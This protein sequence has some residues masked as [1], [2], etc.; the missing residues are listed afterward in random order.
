MAA[1]YIE[2]NQR[3]YNNTV[4][5]KTYSLNPGNTT[6]AITKFITCSA[7]R[8]TTVAT[9]NM[10][11]HG[12][13]VGDSI[14]VTG[15]A[16]FAGTF[17]IATVPDGDTFTYAVSNANATSATI[18]VQITLVTQNYFRGQGSISPVIQVS[19]TL[20][21]LQALFP[22]ASSTKLSVIGDGSSATFAAVA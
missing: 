4:G 8:V 11:G 14:V 17:T 9:V 13:L 1:Q 10:P 5:A 3:K 7:T 16:P 20:T 19:G 2:I 15:L 12:F 22:T 21:A 6:K 18:K